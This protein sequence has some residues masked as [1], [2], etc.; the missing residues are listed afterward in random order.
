M[1]GGYVAAVLVLGGVLAALVAL[2]AGTS[3][4]GFGLLATPL[5]LLSGF[6]L[7]FIVTVNLLVSVAT[8]VSVVYRLRASIEP[9]RVALLVAGGAPGLYA[10]ARL[11]GSVDR[12][13]VKVAVGVVIMLAAAALLYA[14]RHPPSLEPRAALVAVSGFLGGV[15]GT[16]TSLIGVP[17]A[18]LLARRRL[19]PAHFFA[20]MAV[21][22]VVTGA[23][24]VLVLEIDGDFSAAGAHAFLW[25]LPGV[26]VANVVGTSLGLRLPARAFRLMTLSLALAAGGVT[27]LTA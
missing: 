11:L 16:T 25:W 15:L 5:L 18:L 20:D 27:V 9:R 17:P 12:H 3:G 7:P 21:F 4:F 1:G 10:G 14:E 26:L 19:G 2:L 23:I 22:F 13:T 24:G 6:S 8:R